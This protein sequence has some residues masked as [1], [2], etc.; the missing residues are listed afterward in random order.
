[1]LVVILGLGNLWGGEKGVKENG[2]KRHTAGVAD[3]VAALIAP[4]EGCY[5]RATVLACWYN[6]GGFLTQWWACLRSHV[7]VSS[8]AQDVA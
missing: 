1:V 4:P 2:G 8:W 3:G 5:G 6:A 7:V